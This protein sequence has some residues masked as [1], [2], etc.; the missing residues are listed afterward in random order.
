MKRPKTKTKNTT[1]S[2]TKNAAPLRT[3]E[4]RAVTGGRPTG[5]S[6]GPP[7]PEPGW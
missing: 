4:L 2:G 7:P 5:G 3:H 6:F 1:P